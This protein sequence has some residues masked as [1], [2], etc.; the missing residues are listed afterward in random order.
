MS[1]IPHVQYT[2]DSRGRGRELVTL[3]PKKASNRESEVV[4]RRQ[5]GLDSDWWVGPKYCPVEK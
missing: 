5:D 4:K 3:Y 1:N 2:I